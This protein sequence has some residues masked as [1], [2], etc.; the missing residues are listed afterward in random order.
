MKK[1]PKRMEKLL[2]MTK[3]DENG[4]VVP[5]YSCSDINFIIKNPKLYKEALEGK[6]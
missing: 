4:A 6:R 1:Y 3:V 5:K 2:R